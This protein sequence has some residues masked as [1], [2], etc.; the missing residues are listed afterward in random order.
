MCRRAYFFTMENNNEK[1]NLRG[2]LNLLSIEIKKLRKLIPNSYGNAT[3]RIE[4]R[5]D[6]LTELYKQKLNLL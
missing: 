3:E 5:L 4:L 6:I 1:C 2:E